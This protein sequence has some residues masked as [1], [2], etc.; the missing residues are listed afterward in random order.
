MDNVY[1]VEVEEC[2]YDL[3]IINNLYNKGYLT[4]EE[5]SIVKNRILDK[6]ILISQNE[7]D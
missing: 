2:L 3:G 1:Q 5:F 7:R 4:I 6:M